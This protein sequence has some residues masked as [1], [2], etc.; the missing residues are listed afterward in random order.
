[1]IDFH[2]H[3]IPNIDDGSDSVE[4]SLAMLKALEKEDVS[5]VCLTPH[6]YAKKEKTID[7]FI[8]KRNK[9]FEL[10]NYQGDMILK[11]GAEICY[12]Y[13]ISNTSDI[14]K[15]CIE[16][17]NILLIELPFYSK[18]SQS[19][20]EELLKLQQNGFEVMI[21]HIERTRLS[22]KQL[23]T[24]KNYGIHMQANTECIYN[25]GSLLKINKMLTKNYIDAFGTDCH[26]MNDRKPEYKKFIKY[27][28]K[29]YEKDYIKNI[30]EKNDKLINTEE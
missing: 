12:Y 10:L 9:Q 26:N 11:L 17:T 13:G 1:M 8:E 25:F 14:N 22:G 18:I 24:L 30:I 23:E 15:L 28:E 29:K 20:I 16:G 6:F 2:T 19:T 21:A 3:I 7:D 4:T 5:I 27:V